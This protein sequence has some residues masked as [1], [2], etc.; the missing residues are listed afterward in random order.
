MKILPS[1]LDASALYY[2]MVS[3][4]VPRPIAFV[5]TQSA[6]GATNLA[7][8][9]YYNAVSSQPPMVQL[10]IGQRRWEGEL[11][12]KDTLRN[13]RE[14]EEFVVN[15]A[16]EALAERLNQASG[17]YAPG[18][19]EIEECGLT[20]I[21]SSVVAPPRIA[22]SPVQL[23]CKLERIL[24]LGQAPQ[25]HMVIGEVVCV[26]VEDR[27]WDADAHSVNWEQLRPLA[28]LGGTLY[29]TLGRVFSLDRPK[30]K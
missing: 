28:R 10:C 22:E 21:P 24:G 19:S 17:S 4:V 5:S 2:L 16:T 25:T 7:P 15:V 27:L 26:H 8:F 18:V 12:D 23:E 29:S 20:A 11:V 14:T 6:A 9:S 1:D 30:V 3:A 13:I